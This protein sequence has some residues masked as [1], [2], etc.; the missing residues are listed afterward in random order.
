MYPGT[1]TVTGLAGDIVPAAGPGD[2]SFSPDF[3]VPFPD[4]EYTIQRSISGSV[5]LIAPLTLNVVVP[6]LVSV[7]P[8]VAARVGTAAVNARPATASPVA[9]Y[10]PAKS[11]LPMFCPLLL[12]T[13]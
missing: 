10:F 9:A 11:Q 5:M 12:E 7:A 4:P 6:S 13:D 1:D 2:I 8:M 3:V